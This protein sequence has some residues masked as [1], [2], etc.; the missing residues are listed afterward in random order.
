[1]KLI[2]ALKSG[3]V[4]KVENYKNAT[5]ARGDEFGENIEEMLIHDSYT[6]R[7]IGDNQ[8]AVNGSEI[9]YIELVKQ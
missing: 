8:L 3:S 7:F 4:I 6:Y 2:V 9:S 5:T 1:M